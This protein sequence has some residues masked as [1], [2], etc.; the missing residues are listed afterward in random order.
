MTS[1]SSHNKAYSPVRMHLSALTIFFALAALFLWKS[2][3]TGQVFLP[4]R[5]LL[6]VA[7]YNGHMHGT[8]PLPWNPLRWDGIAQFYPWRAFTAR[9]F[10]QGIVPLWNPYSFC[11]TPFT[12]NSQSAVLYPGTWLFALLPVKSAF[13]VN[14]LIHLALCGWFT[15]LLLQEWKLDYLASLLGGIVFAWS[16]WQVNWLQLPTFLATSCWIPLLLREVYRLTRPKNS[17]AGPWIGT[18]LSLGLMLLAGH[19]QIAFYGLLAGFLWAVALLLQ[20]RFAIR[21]VA[22]LASAAFTGFLISSPQFLPA[23]ELSTMSHRAGRPTLAGY[24]L[25]TSYSLQPAELAALTLPDF[26]GN[27]HSQNNHYWGFYLRS[28]QGNSFAIRH[29]LAETSTYI[30]IIPLMLA[31]LALLRGVKRKNVSHATLFFALMA[32]FAMLMALGTPLNAVFYFG[33]PGFGQSGSPARILVLWAFSVAIL[34]AFGLNSLLHSPTTSREAGLSLLGVLVPFA[35]GLALAASALRTQLPGFQQL[36]VPLLGDALSRI[37]ADW[38]RMLIMTV[39]GLLCMS[40]MLQK[41]QIKL[42]TSRVQAAG[43]LALI[44]VVLDLFWAG[45]LNN[46]VSPPTL[47]Y[48]KTQGIKFLQAHVKHQRIWPVN[49][50]WSLDTAPPAVLPPNGGMVYGLRDVQGYDSLFTGQYKAFA[51]RFA[52]PNSQGVSDSSPPEV[53]NMIFMQNP[54]SAGASLTGANCIITLPSDS[55]EFVPSEQPNTSPLYDNSMAIYQMPHAGS[56]AYFQPDQTSLPKTKPKFLYDGPDRVVL[57]LHNANPGLLC[58]EDEYYPGW[59]AAIDARPAQLLRH[60]GIFRAVHAAAG[61]HT[62]AFVYRP[63]SYRL[64]LYLYCLA[65]GIM[66]LLY[67][68]C[69]FAKRTTVRE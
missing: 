11:G 41:K 27:D 42:F 36:Q 21:P 28:F 14:A 34:A 55:T 16:A 59:K 50:Y 38:L 5:L 52:V 20:Q 33:I 12:A 29:N 44:A 3:F 69:R 68:A 54:N 43:L 31:L 23:L 40:S 7:P 26:F 67:G 17:Q 1:H 30:G 49:R 56:R 62:V 58:L 18:A 66:A 4:A 60:N 25:Y 46:P 51:D 39:A 15:Y 10:H 9:S 35:A 6:N 19:L 22:L 53:G 13:A 47:V 48:P 32:L 45:I 37:P 63:A 64:G 57:A 61:S 2:L 65:G 8:S 24:H